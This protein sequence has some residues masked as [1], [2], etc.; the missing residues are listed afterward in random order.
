MKI[1]S[2]PS[3]L[4]Y[5]LVALLLVSCKAYKQ[6]ILFQLDDNFTEN[7]LQKPIGDAVGNY[8]LKPGDYF[9][10]RVFSNEGERIIDPDFELSLQNAGG[11]QQNTSRTVP[12]YLINAEGKSSLPM[13]G[14]VE[15][16]GNTVIEAE[17]MLAALY[18]EFYS[19]CYVRVEVVNR[20]VVVLGANGGEVIPL[21]NEN[22]SVAEVLALSGG[23][24]FG[25]KANAI[26]LIRGNLSNPMVYAIDLTTIEGMRSTII[27][28][29]P[30]D[31]IYIQ[32]WRRPWL[33]GLRDVSSIVGLTTGLLTFI[34][35]LQNAAK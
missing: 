17:H 26:K 28:V 11:N 1:Y 35:F 10:F 23:V 27:E 13:I 12:A 29:Q 20:R 25:A 2:R 9:N 32:P 31:I 33:E 7:D 19:T 30:G 5:L 21:T 34:L 22:M 4:V 3:R 18:T 6:D 8:I 16:Q 24:N 15:L 14:L